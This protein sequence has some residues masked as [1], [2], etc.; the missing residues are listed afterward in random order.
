LK[1]TVNS[2]AQDVICSNII[3]QNEF[4]HFKLTQIE[5]NIPFA[6]VDGYIF[7]AGRMG[8]SL[9]SSTKNLVIFL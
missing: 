8:S 9:R 1:T 4:E 6:L 3:E 2:K 5:A 7:K